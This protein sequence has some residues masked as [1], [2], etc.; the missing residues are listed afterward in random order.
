[1]NDGD[2][3]FAKHQKYLNAAKEV[4][5]VADQ[6]D[7]EVQKQK[8]R[9][10]RRLQKAKEKGMEGED[11]SGHLLNSHTEWRRCVGR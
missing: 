8:R 9:E 6:E 10:K 11:V 5:Q 2:N 1:M 4:M 7:K 3:V